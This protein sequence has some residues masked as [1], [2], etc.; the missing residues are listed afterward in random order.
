MSDYK[1]IKCP[2]CS[3]ESLDEFDICPLCGLIIKKYHEKQRER[4]EIVRRSETTKVRPCL[5]DDEPIRCPQ[6]GSAQLSW[7]K[8]GFGFGKAAVGGILLGPFGLLA[9]GIGKNKIT[10]TCLK[11]GNSWQ[12]GQV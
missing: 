9:G 6:C 11:C 7:N 1:I 12:P 5:L 8:N 3:Y 10:C 4:T 2:K